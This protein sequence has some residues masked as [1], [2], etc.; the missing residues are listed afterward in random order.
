M[1][2]GWRSCQDVWGIAQ[3]CAWGR[4]GGLFGLF[5]FYSLFSLI[6][7][8]TADNSVLPQQ[9]LTPQNVL[10]LPGSFSFHD[11]SNE[12][13]RQ[14]TMHL[15]A[16]AQGGVDQWLYGNTV[17]PSHLPPDLLSSPGA[18]TQ[19]CAVKDLDRRKRGRRGL[20]LPQWDWTPGSVWKV[21]RWRI[22]E[23]TYTARWGSTGH[24]LSSPGQIWVNSVWKEVSFCAGLIDI[25]ERMFPKASPIFI[26]NRN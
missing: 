23:L 13:Y 7:N 18:S 16:P 21:H 5:L 15:P 19:E 26:P 2:K 11:E 22:M 24:W 3:V 6:R 25:S 8:A 20:C 10:K 9:L 1:R 12:P 4:W 17:S 14:Q